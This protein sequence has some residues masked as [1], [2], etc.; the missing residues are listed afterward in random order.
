MGSA[1][2]TLIAPGCGREESIQ[3]KPSRWLS[4]AAILAGVIGLEAK[5][6]LM[7]A[8]QSRNVE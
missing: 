4:A 5:E 3:T 7:D 8:I 2:R 6:E 1:D